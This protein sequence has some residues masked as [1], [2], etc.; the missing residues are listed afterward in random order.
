MHNFK[1]STPVAFMIYNRP[2]VTEQVFQRIRNA[3]PTKLLIVADGPNPI[4]PNDQKQCA[5]TRDIV[6]NIDWNCEVLRNRCL[7]YHQGID[8][9][10]FR[11]SGTLH[12][13][14]M[15]VP[16]AVSAGWEPGN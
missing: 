3:K 1:L 9:E 11:P 5:T 4:R 14:T 13:R 12:P 8:Q 10:W 15:E 16:G 7:S 2:N 6:N